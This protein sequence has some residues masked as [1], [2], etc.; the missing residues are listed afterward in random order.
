MLF[1]DILAINFIVF[2]NMS[3]C[4]YLPLNMNL[5]LFRPHIGK[6]KKGTIFDTKIV[7]PHFRTRVLAPDPHS[8]KN[9]T[10]VKKFCL[11][12][13]LVSFLKRKA[14]SNSTFECQAS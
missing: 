12:L 10:L 2:P 5:L 8:K 11:R 9:M 13:I 14:V 1:S 4:T 6:L 7:N 3:K